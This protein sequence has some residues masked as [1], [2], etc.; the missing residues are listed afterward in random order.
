MTTGS[1]GLHVV[2]PLDRQ[3]NFDTVRNFA[4]ELVERLADR[5]PQQLTTAVRKE[6]RAGRVFLDYL[7]N[8]YGQT[9]VS[10]YAVRAK[11][12][13]PVATPL[14][15]KELGNSELHA[16]SY[17]IHNIFR[18]LGQKPDPWTGMMAQDQAYALST[19]KERLA[20][21]AKS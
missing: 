14:E 2:V 4:R 9:A 15:W 21:L 1:Q 3:A 16:Q 12:G 11:A 20:A 6:K 10:P 13:A 18:R 17:T 5:A 19:A 7:R 8:A